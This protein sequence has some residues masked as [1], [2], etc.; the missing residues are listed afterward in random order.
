MNKKGFTLVELILVIVIIAI[1]GAI[2]IPNII[3]LYTESRRKGGESIEELL[4]KNLE[5]YNKDNEE[6]IWCTED[7]SEDC[8]EENPY[9]VDVRDL[10][11]LNPDI[12]MGDCLLKNDQSLKI[13]KVSNRSYSYSAS[14]VC[15]KA[16]DVDSDDD[17]IADSDQLNDENIYYES[18]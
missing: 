6:D 17:K 13:S 18:K 16:F 7:S 15:S 4:E 9:T 14:I 12:D 5:L 2:T 11:N 3:E 8:Y 1:I 10:F